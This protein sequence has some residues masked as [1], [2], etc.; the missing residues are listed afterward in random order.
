MFFSSEGYIDGKGS[1]FRASGGM[2]VRKIGLANVNW[3]SLSPDFS[4]IWIESH[5]E[6]ALGHGT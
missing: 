6:S 1:A 2:T 4:K 3:I 5:C